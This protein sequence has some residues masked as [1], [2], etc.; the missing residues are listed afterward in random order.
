MRRH[1]VTALLATLP[2]ILPLPFRSLVAQ[3]PPPADAGPLRWLDL[4]GDI[5]R[6]SNVSQVPGKYL[7]HPTTVQLPDGSILCVYPEGH[8][9]GPIVL[10]RSEDGGRTW[11][12]RLPVLSERVQLCAVKG[13]AVRVMNS[14]PRT[15]PRGIQL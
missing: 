2:A 1:L 8:G 6:Q 7:G 10:K 15:A 14:R 9:K 12:A 3:A 4:D 11:S 13:G 5:A